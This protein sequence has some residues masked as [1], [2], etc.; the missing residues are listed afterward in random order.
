MTACL[1]R[2]DVIIGHNRVR[3]LLRLMGLEAIEKFFDKNK[4]GQ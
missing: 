2:K 3:R 1:H 4:T